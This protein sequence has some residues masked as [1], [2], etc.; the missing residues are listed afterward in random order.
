MA[1]MAI[2][3]T[4]LI[5]QVQNNT[6]VLESFAM[7]WEGDVGG[8]GGGSLPSEPPELPERETEKPGP[9]IEVG[10]GPA[11]DFDNNGKMDPTIYKQ[12][13]ITGEWSVLEVCRPNCSSETWEQLTIVPEFIKDADPEHQEYGSGTNYFDA[14]MA[15]I[16]GDLTPNDWVYIAENKLLD[17]VNWNNMVQ[18]PDI[19]DSFVVDAFEKLNQ[20]LEYQKDQLQYQSTLILLKI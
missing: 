12:D 15:A 19:N 5:W 6:Q 7:L 9:E 20:L 17:Q 2:S 14:K 11:T 1:L 10:I 8:G 16:P 13:P 4:I 18:R 3:T